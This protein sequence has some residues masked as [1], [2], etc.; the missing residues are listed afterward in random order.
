[1][2]LSGPKTKNVLIF[3]QKKLS[4][5]FRKQ[6]FQKKLLIFQSVTLR[7]QKINK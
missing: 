6:N 4:L 7:A 3:S 1:M 2:K 5:Y